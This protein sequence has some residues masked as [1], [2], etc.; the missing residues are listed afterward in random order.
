MIKYYGPWLDRLPENASDGSLWQLKPTA[1]GRSSGSILNQ[2]VVQGVVLSGRVFDQYGS[3]AL[4]HF[5]KCRQV[6]L[7][8]SV[9]PEPRTQKVGDLT[10]ASFARHEHWLVRLPNKYWVQIKAPSLTRE[11]GA[12]V[13]FEGFGTLHE[14]LLLSYLP[15]QLSE[16]GIPVPVPWADQLGDN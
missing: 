3:V 2:D 12:W 1:T 9:L 5:D 15:I 16:D 13:K 7:P 8:G 10:L 11:E 14:R 6:F 4:S